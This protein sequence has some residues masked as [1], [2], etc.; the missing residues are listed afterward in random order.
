MN[1]KH[2]AKK[3]AKMVVKSLKRPRNPIEDVLDPDRIAEVPKSAIP[4]G[5][6]GVMYKS[7]T[8]KLKN[9]LEKRKK[10]VKQ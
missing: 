9:F 1:K 10:K 3:I 5:R 6:T 4:L 7:K 8:N 2:D